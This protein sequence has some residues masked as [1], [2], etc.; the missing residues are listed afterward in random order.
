MPARRFRLE[1]LV[2]LRA[3]TRDERRRGLAQALDAAAILA[4]QRTQLLNEQEAARRWV[5][6][7]AAMGRVDVDRCL[8]AGRYGLQ[9]RAQLAALAKQEQQVAAEVERRRQALVEADRQVRTLEKLRERQEERQRLADDRQA[10]KH[11]DEIAG[12]RFGQAGVLEE[13]EA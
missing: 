4:N 1:T 7:Q 13:V 10:V 12:Q 9:L 11:M 6:D 3:Q 8:A 5:V 2:K